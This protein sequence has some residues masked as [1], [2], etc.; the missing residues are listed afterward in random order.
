M[1][2][3]IVARLAL[4]GCIPSIRLLS[5]ALLCNLILG[6]LEERCCERQ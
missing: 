3:V 2:K 6:E 4:V 5:Y 1:L